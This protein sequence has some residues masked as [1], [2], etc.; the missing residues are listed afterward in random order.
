MERGGA[1]A[2]RA[3][4]IAAESL[5]AVSVIVPAHDEAELLGGALRSIATAA[6]A[7]ELPVLLVVVLDRCSDASAALAA[8]A[9]DRYARLEV[10][11]VAGRFPHVGAVR[12]A[13]VAEAV[14]ARASVPARRHWTA[15][16]DADTVVPPHWLSRQVE[17]ADSGVDLVIGTAVPDEAPGTLASRLWHERHLLV[18]GH[19]AVHGANLGIR[20]DGLLAIGGFAELGVGEDVETVRRLRASGVSWTATDT[21]RVTT[22]ARRKGR[23]HGGFSGFMRRLDELGGP[24]A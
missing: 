15:H 6:E 22:S 8:E 5:A 3:V 23:V 7:V 17:I 1:R 10:R 2:V 13:G 11:P 9:V 20:L 24:P 16:T 18:E 19:T 12:S 4:L 21:T 14:R